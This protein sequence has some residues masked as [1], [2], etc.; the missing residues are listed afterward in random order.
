[1]GEINIPRHERDALKAVDQDA[2]RKCIGQGLDERSA[3]PLRGLGLEGCGVFVASKYRRY[4]EALTDYG[5]AKAARKTAET[6]D[7]ARRAGDELGWAVQQMK[8]RVETEE[9]ED[10]VFHIEDCINPPF[11]FS[12]DLAVYVSY[13]WRAAVGDS[14]TV[15]TIAFT[16]KFIPRPDYT[17]PKPKR[18]LSRAQEARELQDVLWSEWEFLKQS[19][20][21]SLKQYF[22]EGGKAANVPKTFTARVDSYS[23]RLNNLSTRFWIEERTDA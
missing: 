11:Q 12:A 20:L 17:T 22:R 15:G 16:H 13:R 4:A 6:E 5:A 18:K 7:R 19:A 2:L 1:M 8:G 3:G 21:H 10:Q 9:S 23:R 14:W